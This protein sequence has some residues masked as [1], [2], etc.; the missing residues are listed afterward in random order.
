M[1]ETDR[2][3]IKGHLLVNKKQTLCPPQQR[4]Q[5]P[6]QLH[7]QERQVCTGCLVETQ[8]SPSS[9]RR[10]PGS[11]KTR[12]RRDC[13]PSI[14]LGAIWWVRLFRVLCYDLLLSRAELWGLC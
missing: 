4:A 6:C 10:Y 1:L 12:L 8:S 7:G 3:L 13:A 2:K 14:A 9:S 11:Q 5:Q